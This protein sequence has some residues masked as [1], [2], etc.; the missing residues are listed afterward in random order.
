MIVLLPDIWMLG[1]HTHETNVMFY[2][3]V[4]DLETSLELIPFLQQKNMN[5]K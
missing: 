5:R 4:K 1:T 2:K 3:P